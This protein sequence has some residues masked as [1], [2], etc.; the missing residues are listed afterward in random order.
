MRTQLWQTVSSGVPKVENIALQDTLKNIY[1][2]FG[3]MMILSLRMKYPV[4]LIILFAKQFQMIIW[5]STISM[6]ISNT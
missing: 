2:F 1:A 3:N 5:V 6:L 4:K